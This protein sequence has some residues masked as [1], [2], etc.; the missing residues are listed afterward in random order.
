MFIS[1]QVVD[2]RCDEYD[3][4]QKPIIYYH[5]TLTPNSYNTTIAP[6]HKPI[7]N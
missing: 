4:S 3:S 1:P 2:N 6:T 5:P 7:V